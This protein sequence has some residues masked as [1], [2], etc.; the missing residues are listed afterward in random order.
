LRTVSCP[1]AVT[2]LSFSQT[3]GLSPLLVISH[4]Q[5]F[6]GGAVLADIMA[7]KAEFWALR[8]NWKAKGYDH[9]INET[10]SMKGF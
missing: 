5:V 8:S 7:D 4:P 1:N 3:A 10:I 2:F 6:L 9:A